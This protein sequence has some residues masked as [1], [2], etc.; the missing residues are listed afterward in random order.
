VRVC[1]ANIPR[2][3]LD[4]GLG[5]EESIV[6]LGEL[7]DK[8]LVL[9]E[10]LQVLNGHEGKLLVELL[11]TVDIGSI[12]KNAELHTGSGNVGELDSTGLKVSQVRIHSC[13]CYRFT[14]ETLVPLG[15]V[16]L[17]TDLEL[18]GLDEVSLLTTGLFPSGLTRLG[19]EGL[20]RG[21]HA[22]RSEL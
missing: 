2:N 4:Q 21:S 13:S 22:G 14:H 11:S 7:L 9:V 8:L 3:L 5:S 19:D 17:E 1:K 6:L 10:L 15:V 16:V 12:G 18:N 20:D